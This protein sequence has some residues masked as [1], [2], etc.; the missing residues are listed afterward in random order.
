MHEFKKSRLPNIQGHLS[1]VP[2]MYGSPRICAINIEL[3]TTNCAMLPKPPRKRIGLNSVKNIGTK[4]EA[5]PKSL[6]MKWDHR[7]RSNLIFLCKKR[8]KTNRSLVRGSNFV[9][10]SWANVWFLRAGPDFSAKNPAFYT[11]MVDFLKI[12]S[13]PEIFR[14]NPIFGGNL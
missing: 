7:L 1:A 11:Q 14:W 12:R 2:K 13:F 3:V 5:I 4:P 6:Q 9:R 10:F 8:K